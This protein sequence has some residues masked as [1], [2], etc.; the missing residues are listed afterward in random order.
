MNWTRDKLIDAIRTGQVAGGSPEEIADA[1]AEAIKRER[2]GYN[3]PPPPVETSI[4]VNPNAVL[5]A[6]AV[7]DTPPQAEPM[8]PPREPA[9]EAP[10]PAPP[11]PTLVLVSTDADANR[12]IQQRRT[13]Q[14]TAP[15]KGPMRLRSLSKTGTA[16]RRFTLESAIQFWTDNIPK[17]LTITPKGR[18]KVITL[19]RNIQA[20]PGMGKPGPRGIEHFVKI[21][22]K[23]PDVGHEMEVQF[24]V[25]TYDMADGITTDQIMT[26]IKEQAEHTYRPRQPVLEPVAPQPNFLGTMNISGGIGLTERDVGDTPEFQERLARGVETGVA[27]NLAEKILKGERV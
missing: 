17:H 4:P 2:I 16:F 10:T 23:H 14:T 3:P 12:E 18:S 22:F 7:T 8:L 9:A 26:K 27:E 15:P 19:D 25:S 6:S 1:I 20:L 11:G 24:M 21:I 5:A 13:I